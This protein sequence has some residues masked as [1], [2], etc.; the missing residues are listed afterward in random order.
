VYPWFSLAVA[1][2]CRNGFRASVW[3]IDAPPP[4]SVDVSRVDACFAIVRDAFG[5]CVY[6]VHLL[7]G[8][9]AIDRSASRVTDISMLGCV[10]CVRV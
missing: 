1:R 10:V 4:L 2:V 3:I 6:I 9:R 7:F 8:V 5:V